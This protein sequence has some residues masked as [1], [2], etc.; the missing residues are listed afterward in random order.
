MK[1]EATLTDRR[2]VLQPAIPHQDLTAAIYPQ[3]ATQFTQI[4]QR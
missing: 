4:D 3:W 2:A 1:S